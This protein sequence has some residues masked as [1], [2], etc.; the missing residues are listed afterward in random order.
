MS[1]TCAGSFEAEVCGLG[2]FLDFM[3]SD[4]ESFAMNG[5]ESGEVLV[6]STTGADNGRDG[7]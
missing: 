2:A 1:S 6:D 7:R 5:E 4:R 3:T